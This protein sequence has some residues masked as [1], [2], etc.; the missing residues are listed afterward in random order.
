[1][2][3][4]R[5]ARQDLRDLLY[6]AGVL[7]SDIDISLVW[8]PFVFSC[9]SG[10]KSNFFWLCLSIWSATLWVKEQL[11]KKDADFQLTATSIFF[12]VLIFQIENSLNI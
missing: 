5:G 7:V 10:M 6:L 8:V 12:Y 3:A 4:G 2:C 11:E 9:F 1:M